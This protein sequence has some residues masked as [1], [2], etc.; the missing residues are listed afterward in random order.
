MT[1][2]EMMLVVVIVLT[3]LAIAIPNIHDA[4]QRA[5]VARAVLEIQML[6]NDIGVG[7][8]LPLSLADLGYATLRDPWGNPYVYLNFAEA[9][10]GE[11]GVPGAA[12]K[13]RFLVPLNSLYDLYS[14]GA[15]GE[16]RPPL[17]AKVSHD[18]V[19]RA[20]DGSFIGL[21]KRF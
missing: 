11:G 1:L 12:R 20:N 18:D 2:V 19:I 14:K 9:T 15:D 21:A 4:V 8:Q 17:S 5:K 16:S 13:D 7:D 6:Q 10:Q 3:L